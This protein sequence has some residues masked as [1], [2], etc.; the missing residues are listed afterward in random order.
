MVFPTSVILR[1]VEIK[2]LKILAGR[3]QKK[4]APLK[5]FW[6]SLSKLSL[7]YVWEEVRCGHLIWEEEE[8]AA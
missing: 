8:N 1:L 3:W 6:K 4:K 7:V 2:A 5:Y